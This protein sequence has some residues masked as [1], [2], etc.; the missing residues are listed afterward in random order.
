M[1]LSFSFFSGIVAKDVTPSHFFHTFFVT[2]VV[3]V[4]HDSSMFAWL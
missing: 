1:E 2:I 4:T 3:V